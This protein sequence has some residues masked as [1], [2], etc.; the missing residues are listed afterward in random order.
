MAVIKSKEEKTLNAF[1]R[2]VRYIILVYL[3]CNMYLI[4]IEYSV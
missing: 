4:Q 2:Y 3:H 1:D